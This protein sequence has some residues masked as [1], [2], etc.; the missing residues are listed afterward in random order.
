M[1]PYYVI[2]KLP[3]EEKEEF[4][5]I[6]PFTPFEK[7]TMVAWMAARNDTAKLWPELQTFTFAGNVSGPELVEA[8][9]TNDDDIRERLT[10]LC[11]PEST[12]IICIR[13]NLLVVPLTSE[14]ERGGQ[15]G[16]VRRAPLHPP[17]NRGLPSVEASLCRR[18]HVGCDG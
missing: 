10:L 12:T 14:G 15:H 3:G 1:K 4:V 8:R 18:R 5:L 7:K 13:G 9:I 17:G 16:A 6:M 11:P 2:M